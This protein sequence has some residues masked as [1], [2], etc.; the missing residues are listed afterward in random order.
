M[1]TALPPLRTKSLRLHS[2]LP[3]LLPYTAASASRHAFPR[4]HRVQDKPDL[5][6]GWILSLIGLLDGPCPVLLRHAH[7]VSPTA[8]VDGI[9]RLS[10]TSWHT[11]DETSSAGFLPYVFVHDTSIAFGAHLRI[12][13]TRNV[14]TRDRVSFTE[15]LS[16]RGLPNTRSNEYRNGYGELSKYN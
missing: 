13:A 2:Q 3:A 1:E 5:A 16:T 8:G 4:N 6:L 10:S 9:H 7:N 12:T 11:E 14:V 15:T